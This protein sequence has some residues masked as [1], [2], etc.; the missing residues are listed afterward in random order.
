M[1]WCFEISHASKNV[2][3]LV[4]GKC[5]LF[6]VMT[7]CYTCSRKVLRH[8][9]RVQCRSCYE[10]YHMKCISLEK[11]EQDDIN[12]NT[13][14]W[15]CSNCL[16]DI[17][18]FNQI[19][20]ENEFINEC[21][22][23][24]KCSLKISDLIYN[25]FDANSSDDRLC[26]D[27][28]PD[29]NFYAEENV[30]SGYSCR[31]YLEDQF[32]EKMNSLRVDNGQNLSLCHIN[33]RSLKANLSQLESYLQGLLIEFAI[34][35][36]TETW[37]NESNYDLYHIDNYD[38]VEN[39]RTTKSGGGVGLYVNDHIRY[40][41]RNDMKIFNEYCES[42]FIEIEKSQLS[43][44]K[45]IIVGVMYRPPNTDMK[46][47]NEIIKELL[48]NIK[49]EN[50][51][52]YLM[53]DYNID[54]LNIESH[55]P[56]S[57]YNDIMYSNGFIP[58]ITRPTR[59]TNSSATII[60]NIFTNKL[61]SQIGESLQGI[62]LTDISDH[63]PVFYIAKSMANKKVNTLVS[64][65]SYS[66]KNKRKFLEAISLID[67]TE[68]YSAADTQ[69]AFTLFHGKLREVHDSC[70][71]VRM[72]NKI[73]YTRKPWLT[74]C[75]RDAI[76]KKN[77][78]YRQYLKVRCVRNLYKEYR[79]R[80]KCLLK[81]AEKKHYCDLMIQY[82]TNAK[83]AWKIIKSVI[84]RNRKIKV[85]EQF[86][87]NDG[88]VTTDPKVISNK[89][90]DFFV[91]VGPS[92][93]NKIPHQDTPPEHY[94]RNR[95]L[96][97]FYLEP[98]TENEIIQLIPSLKEAAAGY[99]GLRSSILKLSLPH[100]SSPLIYVINL[101]LIEGIFP[102]EMKIANNDQEM[103]NNYRPVSLLCSLSKVFEKVMYSRLIKFLDAHS[104][105]FS[106][107]FGFRKFHSTYMAIM[108]MVDKLTKHLDNGDFIFG[109]FLDF[110]KAFDTVDH[111]ILVRKLSYYGIR[112]NA[113]AWFQSYLLN[114]KQFV[115]YNGISSTSKGVKCGVPQGSILGPLLFL[116]YIND[117]SNVSNKS[118]LVLF[119]DDTNLFINAKDPDILQDAVNKELA[120]IAKWLKVNKLSLNIKKTQFM[121]FTRRKVAPIKVDIKIDNQ[122][123][124]E[125]KISKFLGTYIDNNLNWKS[126]ISYI[127][128]KIARG[129]GIITKARKYFSSECMISLYH[130]FIYPYLIYCN[131]IWGNTYKSS[132]SKLQVLQNKA[133]R[134][135][136]GSNPR[137]NTELLYKS[138]G[139]LNLH[140]INSCLI[141]K[142]M[143]NVYHRKVP[144]IF[145]GFFTQNHEI[146]DHNTRIA[147]HFHIP[148]CSTNL[149][150]TS[151][152]FQGAI[153]WNKILKSD[154]NPDC[155]EASF[156][157]MLKKCV[158][159][160]IIN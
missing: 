108:T 123:I 96:Y 69:S 65:R 125:T 59:V 28:D 120:D 51:I 86:K 113:L 47:F 136:T 95:A 98:V 88:S 44:D 67:W 97:S 141:G 140:G 135:V 1:Y 147:S 106:Y 112:G 159:Q 101:S 46:D 74:E 17:F 104:I 142:F 109:V 26:S 100:I 27:F 2:Y 22:H 40:N 36:I 144:H 84:N 76:K 41:L 126:H 90:N 148:C 81:A 132:L 39:H 52:C 37:L 154:I 152:R 38:F 35:G 102:D 103:F 127:A 128:G 30:F 110:S 57:D 18:P 131:H 130:S 157:Q 151:I 31:Y 153:M 60:D 66:N 75:L 129:I 73:Y 49:R 24:M 139:L 116:I 19:E 117:L 149:S 82:K 124:T 72:T 111:D 105:L 61:S 91:N 134:I 156:K 48:E 8:A 33:I 5:L 158:L 78:L 114:R 16:A 107:Q 9:Y 143:F 7:T 50:K 56:T 92:L 34:L 14:N 150:Q 64:K 3:Y 71:P 53:G 77:K 80:L 62:L 118:Q 85:N 58:L 29:V 10:Y 99:D 4:Y 32:N 25:P 137:T 15:L 11:S 6:I 122:S 155:S 115:T 54:L 94:L 20:D 42:I 146:H 12:D 63:Y 121:V 68:V 23:K 93:A 55:S 138:N 45:N 13:E 87:L 43:F 21:Q 70:F 160:N 79:N 145:E 133:V 119:A 83:M 89:F